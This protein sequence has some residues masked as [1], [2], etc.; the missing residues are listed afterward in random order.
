MTMHLSSQECVTALDRALSPARQNHLDACPSCQV[1][2]AELG[3]VVEAA[4][5]DADVPE[6]SPLFWDHFHTRVLAAVEHAESSPRAWWGTNWLD[7]RTLLAIGAVVMMV[8]AS[9][10]VYVSR[11]AIPMTETTADA[12]AIE[13]GMIAD[14]T[15]PLSGDEWEFVASVMGTLDEEGMHEVLAPSSNAVDTALEGLTSD[16]RERFIKLL[17]TEKSEGLE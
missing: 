3:A 8:A 10:A 12:G 9:L 16:Q 13:P 17:K 7:A 5:Q 4:A 15:P 14:A 2:V 1:Q 6:P 11:P